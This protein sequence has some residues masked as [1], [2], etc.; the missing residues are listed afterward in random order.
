MNE[1]A[2]S[3]LTTPYQLDAL[4][5]NVI[6]PQSHLYLCLQF[7]FTEYIVVLSDGDQNEVHIRVFTFLCN[8]HELVNLCFVVLDGQQETLF[9]S[10]S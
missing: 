7:G 3:Y 1:G 5:W 10:E 8:I 9:F 2:V 4:P 6:L